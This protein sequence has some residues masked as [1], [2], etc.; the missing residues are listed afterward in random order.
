MDLFSSIGLSAAVPPIHEHMRTP[1]AASSGSLASSQPVL[2]PL[3]ALEAA[4]SQ[5]S[6]D[7]TIRPVVALRD[8]R[9]RAHT[10]R[11]SQYVQRGLSDWAKGLFATKLQRDAMQFDE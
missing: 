8:R 6:A 7:D 9:W 2:F 1:T 5:I 4:L 11:M 3:S 10:L